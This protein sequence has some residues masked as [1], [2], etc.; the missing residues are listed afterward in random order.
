MFKNPFSFNGSIE[1]TE[2]RISMIAY[3][4]YCVILDFATG[5][6]IFVFDIGLIPAVW[7]L[8]AQGA[9]RCH[10]TCQSGWYQLIPFYIFWLLFKENDSVEN[11][12]R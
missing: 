6:K 10:A 1:L 12:Y 8:L 11:D 2:Y 4:V 3:V 7:F 5:N 9:K